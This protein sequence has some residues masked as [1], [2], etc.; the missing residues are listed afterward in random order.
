MGRPLAAEEREVQVHRGK[1]GER[2]KNMRKDGETERGLASVG[3]TEGG[4]CTPWIRERCLSYWFLTIN[5][6][7]AIK[8]TFKHIKILTLYLGVLFLNQHLR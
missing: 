1:Q 7:E 4:I 2:H 8:M 6:Y 5:G 3:V